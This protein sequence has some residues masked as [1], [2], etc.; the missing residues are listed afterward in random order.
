MALT[1]VNHP[2][3]PSWLLAE[4]PGRNSRVDWRLAI[5]SSSSFISERPPA[6]EKKRFLQQL[7]GK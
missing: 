7:R 5:A 3:R 6:D 2:F 4:D 1:A